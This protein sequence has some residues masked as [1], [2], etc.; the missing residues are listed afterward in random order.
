V[1]P[2][3]LP[4]HS[5][6][7]ALY[8]VL[9]FWASNKTQVSFKDTWR[10]FAVCLAIAGIVYFIAL[11]IS[12]GKEKAALFSSLFIVSFF[13][14]GQTYYAVE[15]KIPYLGQPALFFIFWLV[16]FQ[17]GFYLIIRFYRQCEPVN[18]YLNWVSL[19]LV[20]FPLWQLIW[21]PMWRPQIQQPIASPVAI[22]NGN[23]NST[24][25]EPDIYYLILDGYGRSDI[26]LEFFSLD[27]SNFLNALQERG[28]YVAEQSNTNY[29]QTLLSLSSSMTGTYLDMAG[30]DPKS[31]DRKILQQYLDQN[32][33]IQRFNQLGYETLVMTDASPIGFNFA[34]RT[35]ST[36]SALNNFE[37]GFQSLTL[38]RI[39]SRSV[40]EYAHWKILHSELDILE[41]LPFNAEHPQFV[42]AHLL[43]PHPPFVFDAS[44][45]FV[46]SNSFMIGDGSHYQGTREEYVRG[47]S[48]KVQYLNTRL[49]K[50][51]DHLLS[52]PNRP[53][54]II[55][56]GDHGPGSY[57]DLESI[58]N[59]CLQE[60]LPIFNV[61]YLPYENAR[62]M[63]YP[64]I[65]PVNS[66]R[67]IFDQILDQ[68]TPLL[69]DRSFSSTWSH[70][71]NFKDV[72]SPRETCSPLP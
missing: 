7:F 48:R 21:P 27:N 70:P 19:I 10:T 65:S 14:F 3:K 34:D 62:A 63:L 40:Y 28:F 55:L 45:N 50:I 13:Y 11:Q 1:V 38:M 4:F 31:E 29:T 47:Y 60:R 71:Y 57:L 22:Q 66:F 41:Q 16:F 46:P 64:S 69:D 32:S 20:V 12:R 72:S 35:I 54:V 5:F 2:H 26:L 17:F 6:L 30:A 53:V 8:P 61:Y 58:E 42:F 49:I 9:S 33:Y 15:G 25:N 24:G 43:M 51:V 68:P 23:I 52:N 67:L 39:W 36:N 18:T 37:L 56:Q 44:G 59:S